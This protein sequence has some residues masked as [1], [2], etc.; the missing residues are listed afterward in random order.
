MPLQG[1]SGIG[2]EHGTRCPDACIA[3]FDAAANSR[4]HYEATGEPYSTMPNSALAWIRYLPGSQKLAS[5]T[6]KRHSCV[7]RS[8]ERIVNLHANKVTFLSGAG[9]AVTVFVVTV[10]DDSELDHYSTLI[11]SGGAARNF[12]DAEV[13]LVEDDCDCGSNRPT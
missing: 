3:H 6:S 11:T 1:C 10:V 8:S 12:Y 9:T 4:D 7:P 2:S 13:T 5:W